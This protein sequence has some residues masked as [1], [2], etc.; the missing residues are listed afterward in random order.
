M[1][2]FNRIESTANR[3]RTAMNLANKKQIDIVRET[4]IDKGALSSYLKGKYEPKQDVIYKLAKALDVSEMWL[5]G[6]DCPM[7]R[8]EMQ[9]KNDVQTDIVVR[10]RTDS[11]FASL[12]E[13]INQLNP[14]QLA[15][16]KQVVDAFLK[17]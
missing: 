8:H 6:Y 16:I 3:I 7:K 1:S 12:I 15:S 14:D 2:N 9:K 13:G 11:E 4:G 10:L 17:G 5:W